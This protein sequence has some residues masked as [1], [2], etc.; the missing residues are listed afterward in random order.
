MREALGT[1][2]YALTLK[3]AEKL[4]IEWKAW[5]RTPPD[6]AVQRRAKPQIGKAKPAGK[7]RSSFVPAGTR[8]LAQVDHHHKSAGGGMVHGSRIA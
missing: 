8:T 3:G 2:R 5:W 7:G 1:P 6:I 4:G